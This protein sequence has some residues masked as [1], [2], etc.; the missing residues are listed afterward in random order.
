MIQQLFEQLYKITVVLV[1]MEHNDEFQNSFELVQTIL[2]VDLA[3]RR[4]APVPKLLSE[5]RKDN[6][7]RI[8]TDLRECSEFEKNFLKSITSVDETWVYGHDPETK[9][10]SSRWKSCLFQDDPKNLVKFGVK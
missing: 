1:I 2:T 6:R 5:D 7:K 10:P 9:V 3:T 4:V 8:V